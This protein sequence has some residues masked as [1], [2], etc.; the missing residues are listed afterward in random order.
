MLHCR[1][2]RLVFQKGILGEV[3]LYPMCLVETVKFQ[4][5]QPLFPQ[6]AFPCVNNSDDKTSSE[7]PSGAQP[8]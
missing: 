7:G 8:P 5:R 1:E 6:V 2:Y 3:L 4:S